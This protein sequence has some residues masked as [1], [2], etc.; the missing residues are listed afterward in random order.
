MVAGR[1]A[2]PAAQLFRAAEPAHIA[3][4]GDD[5]RGSTGPMPGSAWYPSWHPSRSPVTCS[6]RAISRASSPA[7][8]RSET[9]LPAY[10]C[11]SGSS[12]SHRRPRRSHRPLRLLGRP[13]RT[14][15]ARPDAGP[16]SPG[17]PTQV[18][19]VR[20][21]AAWL[22]ASAG[23]GITGTYNAVGPIVPFG[24]CVERARAV[25]VHTGPVV[26]ADPAWLLK[27]GVAEYMGPDSLPMWLIE[28]GWEG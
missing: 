19:D 22:L 18:I 6:S 7:S 10:G 2:G 25:G 4:L 16:D 24:D 20:D 23:T 3:D 11:G 12:S 5:H 28:P 15:S 9:T 8:I 21:L 17:L 1:Q 26:T 14:R 13:S 27:Q